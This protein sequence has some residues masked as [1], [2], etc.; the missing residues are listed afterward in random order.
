MKIPMTRALA[1][2]IGIFS[3]LLFTSCSSQK[4]VPVPFKIH[5]DQSHLHTFDGDALPYTKWLP[6]E[7]P[8]LIII[9]VHGINGAS[10][11]YRPLA[12]HLLAELPKTAIYGAETRG[13]GK[14]P[15]KERRGH[16]GNRHDWFKDLTSFTSLIRKKHPKAKIIWCGE[17]MGA[18][19]TLHTYAEAEERQNLCDAMI[20]AS[21]I[22]DIRSDF[23]QWKISLANF[24]G[25]LLPKARVSLESFSD[26]E[27]VRVTKDSVH[28]EQAATNSYHVKKHTLRLLTTLGKM[29][30]S[31]KQASQ[32]LNIPL[33]VLHGGKDIFSDPK[34]IEA[35]VAQL[36]KTATGTRKFYPES[37]HLLFH[38]HQSD[39]VIADI[40]AWLKALP[41]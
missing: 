3:A 28:S 8:E 14:D 37:F 17:S 5:L 2:S 39:K 25:F 4:P 21:P 11:D 35:F 27:K 38:D 29:M 40:A 30:Q 12:K 22:T 7:E 9:G 16:I 32:K 1:V 23:P 26:Q 33:L 18:L 19:I 6:Q 13:Q 15:I 34:D 10:S 41:K 20:L 24:A 31:S 36:P